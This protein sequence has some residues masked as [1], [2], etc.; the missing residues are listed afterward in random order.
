[1]SSRLRDEAGISLAVAICS[2]ALMLMLSSIGLK[3][4]VNALHHSSKQDN[5]KRALQA[6]DAAIDTAIFAAERADLGNALVVDPQHPETVTAQNC[7]ISR[8]DV[9]GGVDLAPLDPLA[10]TDPNGRKWCPATDPQPVGDG[11][12]TAQ[13]RLSQ[14]LRV[15]SGDCGTDNTLSLD[16]EIVAVGRSGNVRRRVHARMRAALALLSGAAVQAGSTTQ[17][18]TMRDSARVL[19]D[20]QANAAISGTAGNVISGT[21][22]AGAGASVS[23]VV[24]LGASGSACAPMVL[25]Q[26]DQGTAPTTNDNTLR[27]DGCVDLTALISVSCKPLLVTTGGVTYDPATRSLRVWGNGRAVLTGSTYSFCSIKLENSG[28]LQIQS[29]TPITRIF[30]DDP[31]NCRVSGTPIANAGQI[32]MD[33]QARILNCHLQTQPESLQ[34][35]AKGNETIAT[36]QTL[37]GGALLSGT[38]RAALCGANV[39]LVGEPMVL[40][41][42]RSTIELGGS[43]A[44][45]GQVVGDVVH[46]SGLSTV[47]PVNALI[48]IGRLGANPILPLYKPEDYVECTG[49]DFSDLP[50]HDPA[51]GC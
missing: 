39:P 32:T 4:A 14:L 2:L 22:T 26:V 19:G 29:S 34:L 8:G 51:Q 23:G 27:T 38:A 41:A 35:Y 15:G 33:G 24:P 3:Q 45:A 31:D 6:A 46:M 16:R 49:H 47:Q 12:A 44:I 13:Y 5:V 30:L 10:P 18:L 50:A 20:V 42:P 9:L 17:A 1:L 11:R 37:Q 48:N 43:T 21:A 40:Y 28:I 36:T 25:P 7:V